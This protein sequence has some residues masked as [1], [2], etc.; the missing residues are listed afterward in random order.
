MQSRGSGKLSWRLPPTCFYLSQWEVEE[1]AVCLCLVVLVR[2]DLAARS[3]QAELARRQSAR[4]A[5]VG[6]AQSCTAAT[7]AGVALSF[8]GVPLPLLDDEASWGPA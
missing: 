4:G 6:R 8:S 1:V 2:S 5:Q 7:A 3:R